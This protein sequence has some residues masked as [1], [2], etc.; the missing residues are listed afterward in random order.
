[1]KLPQYRGDLRVVRFRAK[2]PYK[3]TPYHLV[4]KKL[5]PICGD[6]PPL[7]KQ[8]AEEAPKSDNGQRNDCFACMNTLLDAIFQAAK[9]S[10]KK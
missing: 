5:E 10:E 9:D 1:M 2:N 6:R 4:N 8:R 3:E 7:P